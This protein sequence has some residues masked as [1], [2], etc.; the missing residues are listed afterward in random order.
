MR[1]DFPSIWNLK[2][3]INEQKN[4]NELMDPED[5]LRTGRQEADLG[6]RVKNSP[7]LGQIGGSS[8]HRVR[9][10]AW[11]TQALVV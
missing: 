4:R 8:R 2:K 5:I 6:G 10:A 11:G 7:E 3:T 9:G 1:C